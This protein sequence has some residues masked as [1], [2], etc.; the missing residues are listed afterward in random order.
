MQSPEKRDV[1][2]LLERVREGSS[3]ALDDLFEGL[4]EDLLSLIRR[5]LGRSLQAHVESEDILQITFMRAFEHVTE[6][7]GTSRRSLRAW[8][9]RI[10]RNA[11]RDQVDYLKRERRDMCRTLPLDGLVDALCA[12]DRSPISRLICEEEVHCL[13]Q[14]MASLHDRQ[15]LVILL[16]EQEDLSFVEIGERLGKSPDACRMLLARAMVALTRKLRPNITQ[17]ESN[18]GRAGVVGGPLRQQMSR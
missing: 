18:P 13:A 8:L 4:R 17:L 7:R 10:A 15:R 12:A 16:R 11:I 3:E 9:A 1:S 14:A 2:A 5:W 6:F